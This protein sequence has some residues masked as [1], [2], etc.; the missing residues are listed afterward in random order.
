MTLRFLCRNYDH[1]CT[2]K[3]FDITMNTIM[4]VCCNLD[5]NEHI[6]GFTMCQLSLRPIMQTEFSVKI[7]CEVLHEVAVGHVSFCALLFSEVFHWD[8]LARAVLLPA[9]VADGGLGSPPRCEAQGCESS[10]CRPT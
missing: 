7:S 2:V 8:Q 5:H 1:N 6:L 10:T 9:R 4:A 3:L